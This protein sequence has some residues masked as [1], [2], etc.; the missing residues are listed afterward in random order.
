MGFAPNIRGRSW[1]ITV[2]IE[3]MIKAGLTKK[4]YENPEHLANFL[5]S[6]WENSGEKRKAAF[7]VCVSASGLYH[8]HGALYG[9]VTTLKKVADIYFK[10]HVE[11]VMGGK[12]ELKG[13]LKK[14][15]PYD[16]KGEIVLVS[17]GIEKIEDFQGRRTDIEEIEE[18]LSQGKNPDE[19]LSTAFSYRRYE[20]Y[21]KADFID[22]RL[23]ETPL[24]KKMYCEYIFG[25]SGTGKSYEYNVLAEKEGAENI[26]F[27]TDYNSGGLDF[28]L[29]QGAPHILFIDEFKG[30][31]A[32]STLLMILDKYSRAQ[33]HSRYTNCFCLWDKVII[34][35]IYPPEK[36]YEIMVDETRRKTD[37]LTQLMRRL[38]TITYKYREGNTYKTYSIPASE[39]TT[40]E[41]MIYKIK[42]EDGFMDVDSKID[43]PFD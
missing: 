19:I 7:S 12:K 14:E 24:V 5:V 42:G 2:Q 26:Y 25:E 18:M 27:M 8:A 20:K 38:T 37:T 16:E 6:L 17:V 43:V 11:P 9:N 13:Y 28:Y 39:Y 35:S 33:V 30:L 4:E 32:Y 10:S 34:T 40:S 36:V 21:I 31:L 3:N 22:R 23:K 1:I 29:S 41:E 15:P